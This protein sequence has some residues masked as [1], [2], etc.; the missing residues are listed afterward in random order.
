MHKWRLVRLVVLACAGS[1]LVLSGLVTAGDVGAAPACATLD[2][3]GGSWPSYGH[4]LAN[5]RTQDQENSIG[6]GNV[7]ALKSHWTFSVGSKN[8][9]IE[10][11]PAEGTTVRFT[12]PL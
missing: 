5:T 4:D 9:T 11:T 7:S 8:G 2:P 3:G 1:A 12:V 10:S 6:A